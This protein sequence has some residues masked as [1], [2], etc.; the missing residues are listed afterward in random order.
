MCTVIS[1][2][3][4]G[5]WDRVRKLRRLAKSPNPHE[6]EVAAAQARALMEK[7]GLSDDDVDEEALE[8][9]DRESD[10]LRQW[11][12]TLLGRL[13]GCRVVVS[14]REGVGLRGVPGRVTKVRAL[15]QR[16]LDE[17]LCTRTPPVA[18]WL[19][20]DARRV[21]LFAWSRGFSEVVEASLE[22][23]PPPESEPRRATAARPAADAPAGDAER[24]PDPAPQ[25]GAPAGGDG[26]G[27]VDEVRRSAQVLF[28]SIDLR[29]LERD[30]RCAG[31]AAGRRVVGAAL[32]CGLPPKRS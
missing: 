13:C 15:Y 29:W 27:F 1:R 10:A 22:P 28:G 7:H 31:R 25:A 23:L 8:L 3:A 17:M 11:L 4:Q 21:W 20:E 19:E 14:R 18:P 5:V 24:E 2:G 16:A 9:L 30:G 26:E 32:T 12:A 6:A